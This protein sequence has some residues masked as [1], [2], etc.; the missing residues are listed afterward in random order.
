MIEKI[1]LSENGPEVS[2]IIQGFGSIMQDDIHSPQELASHLDLCLELG[3][4]TL[5]LASVYTGGLAEEALGSVLESRKELR[6]RFTIITKY[7]ISGGGPGYHCYDTTL[8]GIVASAEKS[9]RRMRIDAI[10]LLLMH[11]PDMLMNADEVALALDR[12]RKEGKARFFGVSNF[13]ASQFELLSSRLPFPLVTNEIPYS[14][15]NMEYQENGFLDLCQRLRFSP[16]YYSPLGGGKLF[17]SKNARLLQALN[18]L[19][20][21]IGGAAASQ[22]AV[23]WALMHPAKGAAVL[24]TGEAHLLKEA[25]GGAAIKL[26]RDQWFYLWTASKGHEIP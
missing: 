1:R 14:L 5:D 22:V 4:D 25:A 7:G 17:D 12:L 20:Q 10:D 26:S 8:E 13:T 18:E 16:L 21:K 19:G 9:M 3:I 6:K 23:A 15:I 24:G 11:R 2:R